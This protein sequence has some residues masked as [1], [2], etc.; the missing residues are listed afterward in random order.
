V[1]LHRYSLI[2]TFHQS[3]TSN[4][5]G[6]AVDTIAVGQNGADA[7]A[8]SEAAMAPCA[9]DHGT[10]ADLGVRPVAVFDTASFDDLYRTPPVA[11]KANV[12]A[13][14]GSWAEDFVVVPRGTETGTSTVACSLSVT[15]S[16]SDAGTFT[17]PTGPSW[18]MADTAVG[19]EAGF[20]PWVGESGA[21]LEEIGRD[22]PL[23][24]T[25]TGSEALGDRDIVLFV[26]F[27]SFEY[28]AELAFDLTDDGLALDDLV[29][30]PVGVE[31][32]TGTDTGQSG[33]IGFDDYTA[34][35]AASLSASI[36]AG[37]TS[38]VGAEG[39]DGVS[40]SGI[41]GDDAGTGADA[42]DV[43][44]TIVVAESGSWSED[45]APEWQAVEISLASET[46]SPDADQTYSE[47]ATTT[48]IGT[49][50]ATLAGGDGSI[51]SETGEADADFVA[52]ETATLADELAPDDATA[53]LGVTVEVGVADA[54]QTYD[55]AAS[56]GET[57]VADAIVMGFDL[58]PVGA[59]TGAADAAQVIADVF[60]FADAD[61]PN[62]GQ[63]DYAAADDLAVLGIDG[64]ETGVLVEQAYAPGVAE[65]GTGDDEVSYGPA[66]DDIAYGVEVVPLIDVQSGDAAAGLEF[67]TPAWTSDYA[68]GD[69][70]AFVSPVAVETG[71]GA[72][73]AIP[74]GTL[75]PAA[76]TESFGWEGI[77]MDAVTEP[78]HD[79][80]A[81]GVEVALITN[82]HGYAETP[83][84]D[85]E[86][87]I[88]AAPDT[89]P[90][91]A[92]FVTDTAE[93][94]AFVQGD[95]TESA[96]IES[97]FH[98]PQ[99]AYTVPFPTSETT[100]DKRFEILGG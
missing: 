4:D 44:I 48:E 2:G 21:F 35:D 45:L 72:D 7:A 69:D 60:A 13:D 79:T 32:A 100:L 47:T 14:T 18:S 82:D 41:E 85:D 74:V 93:I 90:P 63:D 96:G 40:A 37:D 30:G 10:A 65:A 22:L 80:S 58:S 23:A 61:S 49:P 71:T 38:P 92:A 84:G 26:D 15:L 28:I 75:D 52:A 51:G 53:E 94:E 34:T 76:D 86:G 20:A 24:D 68:T 5:T 8:G 64:V 42:G 31:A 77:T 1:S 16:T 6:V 56:G 12:I 54:S 29:W 89:D 88:E 50:D 66:A 11:L 99:G 87:D 43:G 3:F 67:A 59:D 81:T 55:D 9:I 62:V 27:T 95:D 70:I 78:C 36:L 98:L 97:A 17:D 19:T 83:F 33:R 91:E 46:V 73:A 57:G 25:A 39:G